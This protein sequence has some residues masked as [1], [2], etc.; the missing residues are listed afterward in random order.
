MRP[1][2]NP[3][4]PGKIL[5]EEFTESAKITQAALVSPQAIVPPR[6]C[7]RGADRNP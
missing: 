7:L 5:F 3:F 4:H 2:K 6:Y 1:A